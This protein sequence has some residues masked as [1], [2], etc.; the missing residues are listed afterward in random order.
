MNEEYMS[1][2]SIYAKGDPGQE[3]F[4]MH[5]KAIAHIYITSIGFLPISIG[6]SNANKDNSKNTEFIQIAYDKSLA[7]LG[8]CV[9]METYDKKYSEQFHLEKEME[10]NAQKSPRKKRKVSFSNV[11]EVESSEEEEQSKSPLKRSDTLV[12]DTKI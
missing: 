9:L 10:E 3:G 8:V 4:G 6:G 11:S 12:I 1:R 2:I 7:P 5:D